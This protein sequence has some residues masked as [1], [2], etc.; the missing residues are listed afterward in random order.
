V[1]RRSTLLASVATVARRW[2]FG[3]NVR[4]RERESEFTSGN[5]WPPKPRPPH[6]VLVL[7]I[8]VLVL[9]ITV[10]VLSIT[11]LVLSITVLVLDRTFACGFPACVFVSF[12]FVS[13]TSR[14]TSTS[15]GKRSRMMVGRGDGGAVL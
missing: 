7:S 9:S 3:V 6:T 13:S 10:L 11:V 5:A 14:S 15:R 8:A 1:G 12:C 2:G 4:V